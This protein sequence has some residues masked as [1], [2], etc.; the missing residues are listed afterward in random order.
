MQPDQHQACQVRA[1]AVGGTCQSY[2][3]KCDR[4]MCKFAQ[5]STALLAPVINS[6]LH[7]LCLPEAPTPSSSLPL[8]T[9]LQCLPMGPHFATPFTLTQPP[10]PA[11]RPH[12]AHV[13]VALLNTQ[14]RET[15]RGLT[16]SSVLLGQ[17]HLRCGKCGK[18]PRSGRQATNAEGCP[19]GLVHNYPDLS[20]TPPTDHIL[21]P[22]LRRNWVSPPE[23]S[24]HAH[25]DFK[26]C[27]LTVNLC[28]ISQVLPNTAA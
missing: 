13:V 3:G 27:L 21:L 4:A 22:H 25:P 6:C 8:R 12:L 15:Q 26:P 16:T 7:T 11:S 5:Q 28:R 24:P 9:H 17:V 18:T 1:V 19:R 14:T 20:L 10:P 2:N 23:T